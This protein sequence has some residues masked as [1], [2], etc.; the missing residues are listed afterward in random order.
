MAKVRFCACDCFDAKVQ[1]PSFAVWAADLLVW[2]LLWDGLCRGVTLEDDTR[3]LSELLAKKDAEIK[4]YQ[5]I[6]VHD[7][8]HQHSLR[9]KRNSFCLLINSKTWCQEQNGFTPVSGFTLLVILFFFLFYNCRSSTLYLHKGNWCTR[10]FYSVWRCGCSC[11]SIAR[12]NSG[13]GY[14]CIYLRPF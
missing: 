13:Y 3:R 5:H 2:L 4:P 7:N 10:A 8:A 9:H 11:L 12:Y 6:V 1:S 14:E